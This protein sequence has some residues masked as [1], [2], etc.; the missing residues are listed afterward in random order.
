MAL[1]K[2][3]GF[4]FFFRKRAVKEQTITGNQYHCY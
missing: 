1:V 4:F 3:E 2:M